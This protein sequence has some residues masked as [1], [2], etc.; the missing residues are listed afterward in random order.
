MTAPENW[1]EAVKSLLIV[2]VFFEP[3]HL[4]RFEFPFGGRGGIVFKIGQFG[5]PL[6]KIGEADVGGIEVG[7]RFIEAERDVFG[8]VPSQSGHRWLLF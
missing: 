5:D 8:V 6:V 7:M 1:N 2:F 3:G 4:N